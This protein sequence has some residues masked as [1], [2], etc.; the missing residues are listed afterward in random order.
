[1]WGAGTGDSVRGRALRFDW[2]GNDCA[3]GRLSLSF[4]ITGSESPDHVAAMRYRMQQTRWDVEQNRRQMCFFG[5][6]FLFVFFLK[7][8]TH[9]HTYR[10]GCL[11]GGKGYLQLEEGRKGRV[12]K[13][14]T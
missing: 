3:F 12:R 1:M 4:P 9:M 6:D 10:C 14:K 11:K 5:G 2:S 8:H 13:H 7:D